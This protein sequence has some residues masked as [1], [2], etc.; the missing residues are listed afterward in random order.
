[1][2]QTASEYQQQYF[3]AEGYI[4]FDTIQE[5]SEVFLKICDLN[6]STS[7]AIDCIL[8]DTN[9]DWVLLNNGSVAVL[10]IVFEKTSVENRLVHE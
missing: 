1:M 6:I 7:A 2:V 10:P 3:E 8:N 5:A 9:C 4:I